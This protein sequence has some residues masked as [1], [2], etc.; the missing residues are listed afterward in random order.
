MAHAIFS[1]PSEITKAFCASVSL[2]TGLG[3]TCHG[4]PKVWLDPF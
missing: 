3:S 4:V 2:S 1:S